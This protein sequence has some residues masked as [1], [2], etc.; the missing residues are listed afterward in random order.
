MIKDILKRQREM[1]KY[2]RHPA[3]ISIEYK[4]SGEKVEKIDR[5]QNVS[6]GGLCF[7]AQTCIETG[8]TI[9]L[10]F[11]SINPNFEITGKVVWCMQKKDH[12]YVGVQFL[13]K[14]DAFRARLIEEICYIKKYQQEMFEKE[15]RELT[16]DKAAKE[17]TGKYAK[18]FPKF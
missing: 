4:L 12:V 9:I 1:R 5:T 18:N 2:I 3:D 17:W 8:K 15:G 11:P 14:N 16:D 6:F 7:R 13:D 10:K